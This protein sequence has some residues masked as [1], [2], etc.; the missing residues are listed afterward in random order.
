MRLLTHNYLTSN[1]KGTEKGYP[2]TIEPTEIEC[3]SYPVDRDMVLNLLPKI[4]YGA[5]LRAVGQIAPICDPPMPALP[6]EIDTTSEGW[7][8]KLDE[9]TIN[10]LHRVLFDVHLINGNLVCPDTGRKFPVK[11]SI[12]NMLLHEDEI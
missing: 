5:L 4:E 8:D 7:M 2:L 11:E 10:D 12:P 6:A 9:A 1:V 3:E